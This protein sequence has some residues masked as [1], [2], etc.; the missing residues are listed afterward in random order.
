MPGPVAINPP[1]TGGSGFG[2]SSNGQWMS[3]PPNNHVSHKSQ[4][5]VA[6]APSAAASARFY[7]GL[8]VADLKQKAKESVMKEARG[9][10]A[11]TLIKSARSQIHS[12]R[13]HEAK[14]DLRTALGN[15]IKAALLTKMTMDSQEYAQEN[16]AKGG[17][18]IR[19]E[20]NDLLEVSSSSHSRFQD[21]YTLP[22]D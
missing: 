19:K 22:I 6:A 4:P 8:S 10:S 15:Y 17:G 11:I 7:D 18:V 1:P 21:A 14:G 5:S 16:R 2:S 13:E 12:A 20:L 9:V 3:P